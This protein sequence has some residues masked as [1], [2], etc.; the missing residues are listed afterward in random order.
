M[1][2]E[3]RLT[4][5]RLCANLKDMFV[6]FLNDTPRPRPQGF[7]S[8]TDSQPHAPLASVFL[9]ITTLILLNLKEIYTQYKHNY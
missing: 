1:T 7:K 6:H 5:L 9:S 8:C 2:N 3:T 4:Q